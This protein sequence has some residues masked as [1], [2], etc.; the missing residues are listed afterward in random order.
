MLNSKDIANTSLPVAWLQHLSN[1]HPEW[2]N[3]AQTSQVT[4]YQPTNK[5]TVSI[6][7]PRNV[8]NDDHALVLKGFRNKLGH[9]LHSRPYKLKR[10]TLLRMCYQTQIRRTF[11]PCRIRG[12]SIISVNECCS[13]GLKKNTPNNP[14]SA[15]ASSGG[16]L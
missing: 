5:F 14:A 9:T 16:D 6:F 11:S 1:E 10:Y 8:I 4:L 13:R 12:R 2:D 3:M 7:F 15:D